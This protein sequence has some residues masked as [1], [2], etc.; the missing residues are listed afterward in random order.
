[1]RGHYT[2]WNLQGIGFYGWYLLT[3]CFF[4]CPAN[5][6]AQHTHYSRTAVEGQ[7][8][9]VISQ[10]NGWAWLLLCMYTSSHEWD[11]SV[12]PCHVTL[13]GFRFHFTYSS[14]PLSMIDTYLTQER[15]IILAIVPAN[16]VRRLPAASQAAGLALYS[17]LYLFLSVCTHEFVTTWLIPSL[18]RPAVATACA[19]VHLLQYSI[20][21]FR[22]RPPGQALSPPHY[23][24]QPNKVILLCIY[25]QYRML[26]QWTSLSVQGVSTPRYCIY[27]YVCVSSLREEFLLCIPNGGGQA[28]SYTAH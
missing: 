5:S 21:I 18:P 11:D 27:T 28:Q 19:C 17:W 15:T 4:P 13:F 25:V 3:H 9:E 22:F 2:I 20:L 26:Q 1:M 6:I 7:S 10:V 16:Q 24:F 8:R 14:A 23:Y 12:V